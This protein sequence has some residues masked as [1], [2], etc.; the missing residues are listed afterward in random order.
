MNGAFP[1]QRMKNYLSLMLALLV[2]AAAANRAAEDQSI[3]P[4]NAG[5]AHALIE[6]VNISPGDQTD[7]HISGNLVSYTDFGF[8]AGTVRYYDLLTGI[9]RSIPID[10]GF[11]VDT[12]SSVDGTR[13]AFSRQLS[14][15]T[16][17]IVFDTVTDSFTE[18]DP[19]PDSLR[20]AT[21]IGGS[22][23]AFVENSGNGDI[24][25]YDAP[26]P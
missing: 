14:D 13:I 21:A 11:S 17:I 9:D 3:T 1:E 22:R 25:V 19:Q 5:L 16:A 12:L 20:L 4:V 23:V 18:I 10:D 7:P 26:R 8:G 6:E 24:V 15:R 2:C